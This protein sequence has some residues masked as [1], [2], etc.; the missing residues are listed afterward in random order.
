M[1]YVL[2]LLVY[3]GKKPMWLKSLS[4]CGALTGWDY[5]E[6]KITLMEGY[7]LN[8]KSVDREA[9]GDWSRSVEC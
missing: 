6:E 8:S 1:S 9:L 5:R 4:S 3:V 2:Q 7:D